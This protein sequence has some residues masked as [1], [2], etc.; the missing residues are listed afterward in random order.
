MRPYLRK[1]TVRATILTLVVALVVSFG[2]PGNADPI[3]D[4]FVETLTKSVKAINVKKHLIGIPA[5]GIF[6]GA[7]GIKT[8]AEAELF[9]GTAGAPYDPCYHQACDTIANISETALEVTSDAIA[10]VTATYAFD[11][12]GIPDRRATPGGA[13]RTPAP[14]VIPPVTPPGG[15]P[16][17]KD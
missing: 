17:G 4:P 2:T 12:T 3:S 7:E 13:A 8:P 5:G 6:T 10:A 11:L 1:G 14:P 15:R 16:A 9:G